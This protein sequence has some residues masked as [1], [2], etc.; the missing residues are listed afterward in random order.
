MATPPPL[1]TKAQKTRRAALTW[2]VKYP[3][4]YKEAKRKVRARW[5]KKNPNYYKEWH[6]ANRE[7]VT[8]KKREY[9]RRTA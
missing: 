5:L 7:Y 4:K 2:R 9:R 3:E 8:I 1:L 6:A